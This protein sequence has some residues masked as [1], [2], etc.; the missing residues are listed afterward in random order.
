MLSNFLRL[1]DRI[2][3]LPVIHGSGDFAIEVRRV[4]LAQEFDCLAVPLPPSFQEHV[5]QAVAELP[6]LS[7]VVQPEPLAFEN[8]QATGEESDD[9]LVA[10]MFASR[11]SES[12]ELPACSYVPID[13]CQPVIAALRIALQERMPRAFIDLETANFVSLAAFYP[14][15]Y[16]VKQVSIDRFAA[17][18]LPT[19]PRIPE[20]QPE[21]RVVWMANRLR[22][23]ERRH[24][25]IL[26]VCSMMDW[27]WIKDAYHDRRDDLAEDDDVEPTE[28]FANDP[29]T[30]VFWLGELPFITGL[31]EQARQSLD[32]DENLSIDGVK[33]LLLAARDR[34]RRELKSRGRQITPKMLRTYL[35]YVRN[36]CLIERRMTPDLYSLILA[37][38]QIAGDQ[39]AITLAEMAREYSLESRLQADETD[40]ELKTPSEGGAPTLRMT[41]GV[42]QLP[43]GDVVR[44]K[45][46]LPGQAIVWRSLEL[47]PKPLKIDQDQWRQRWNP[48]HQC[49]WPAED[50]AIENF[51][52]HVKDVALT[53]LGADLVRTEKFS[54]SLKDGLDIRETLRNWH[55]GDLFVKVCPPTR[56]TLDCVLMF[57]DSP[58]D[59]RD[60]PWRITWM[61]EHHDESTL[62]L[63]ATNFHREM[64]GPGIGA[65]NYG[66]AMFLFPPR[67]ISEVWSDP[68]FDFTDT[69]EERLLAAACV[70]SE[71]RHIAVLSESPPGPGWRR[72]AKKHGK[73][74]IH[75]P[76][77]RF[78]QE[79][80]QQ[81]RIVHVLN[82]KQVRSY[83]AHFIR[84]A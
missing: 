61:A 4:M 64:V 63:F 57:F 14:D 7:L 10:D 45:S 26:F 59:P 3:A 34:Y 56:G 51:R 12:D 18:L 31:Y 74:L 69:M 41:N 11:S 16:P 35:H 54:T 83:A 77:G 79:T 13:P 50:V 43:D 22:E 21:G 42:A 73:K 24:E 70:Y 47:K 30:H 37:A 66:G 40:E 46:R 60:Y 71:C 33:T 28:V 78:S 75:V 8:W 58:A 76:L 62:A 15:P 32:D 2:W 65:A 48:F 53:M 81:L 52:T 19:V 6:N 1:S 20:G 67:P 23:L 80:I 5:E 72:L 68:R 25:R 17:A 44:M 9:E 49:S 39:F 84:K 82:G 38:K 27:P 55:T 29:L 36:L